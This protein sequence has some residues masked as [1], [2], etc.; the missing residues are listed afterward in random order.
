MTGPAVPA[1]ATC[2]NCGAVVAAGRFCSACGKPLDLHATAGGVV[3]DALGVR[4]VPVAAYARTAW[5]AVM[6]PADLSRRWVAGQRAGLVS[7]IA[8]MGA[9]TLVTAIIGFFLTRWTGTRE[10]ATAIDMRSMLTVAP[11]LAERFPQA[12]T[13]AAL[14]QNGL[15]DRFRETGGWFAAFWPSLL[16]APG[17][18]ALLPWRRLDQRGALIFAFVESVFLLIL[19]GLHSSLKL[20][21][22]T[23]AA[24]SPITL[25]FAAAVFGHG[26]VHVRGLTGAGWGYALTRPLLAAL[27]IL[28]IAYLWVV[29]VLTVTLAIWA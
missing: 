18:L 25:L 13:A 7:P 17:W 5:L 23:L 12:V 1:V 15:T 2:P 27:W 16:I 8:M 20:V 11:F 28:P 21:L 19:T 4:A 22:P 24:S 3:S 6:A 10:A 14:D 26:A 9:V 29:F